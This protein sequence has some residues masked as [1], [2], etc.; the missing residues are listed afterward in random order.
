MTKYNAQKNDFEKAL[1]RL[2]EALAADKTDMTRDS[3]IQRFE[4]TMDLA[5][6]TVKTFLEEY[7]GVR[8]VS[9]KEC[10]REGFQNGLIDNDPFWLELV[11]IRN[12]TVHT[13]KEEMAEEVYAQL[14]RAAE[15]FERLLARLVSE[16]Q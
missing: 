13:Y 11:D 5:W 12:E 2:K 4:F 7:R 6:K 1:T 3:A 14:P 10:L 15:Y 9:P 16:L 8:C